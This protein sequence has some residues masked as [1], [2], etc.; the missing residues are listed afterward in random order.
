[1]AKTL[2]EKEYFEELEIIAWWV[3]WDDLPDE[4]DYEMVEENWSIYIR[5][6][7]NTRHPIEVLLYDKMNWSFL[8]WRFNQREFRDWCC[9]CTLSGAMIANG[10]MIGKRYAR[11]TITSYLG[12]GIDNWKPEGKWRSSSAWQKIIRNWSNTNNEL[13]MGYSYTNMV[14]DWKITPEVKYALSKNMMV[15]MSYD[16]YADMYREIRNEWVIK[17]NNYSERIWWH[18]SNLKY[19]NGKYYL[20]WSAMDEDAEFIGGEEQIVKLVENWIIRNVSYINYIVTTEA[21]MMLKKEREIFENARKRMMDIWVTNWDR[22]KDPIT[23][24]EARVM[25]DRFEK[26]LDKK[27]W[28]SEEK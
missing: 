7:G 12:Y 9:S 23:R 27:Y 19:E 21:D 10:N 3:E 22:P 24:E 28:E 5:T 6:S 26:H 8:D 14:R 15:R 17:S 25:Y 16:I 20:F 13:K 1:M 2:T 11:S 4:K 18:S